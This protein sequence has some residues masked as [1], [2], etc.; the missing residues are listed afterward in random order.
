MRLDIL[1]PFINRLKMRIV[2]LYATVALKVVP[3]PP[4]DCKC[5]WNQDYLDETDWSTRIE[6]DGE[7]VFADER[8][9]LDEVV[10]GVE[11]RVGPDLDR[12][13]LVREKLVLP[14]PNR[15]RL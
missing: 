11:L 10:V 1:Q 6:S 4:Q 15:Q 13:P 5:R 9:L 12:V 3:T 2:N 8:D 7:S 14:R